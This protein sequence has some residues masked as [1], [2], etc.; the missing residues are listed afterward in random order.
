M[1]DSVALS[2]LI[3]RFALSF[4]MKDWG[5][6]RDCLADRVHTDYSDLRGAPAAT[7]DADDYVRA[8]RDALEHLLLHHV[9]GS[10][11]I[12]IRGASATCRA[13]MMIWRKSG[14]ETFA[15][16]ALYTFGARKDASW[17]L[18][19]ITQKVLWNDG[20]PTIHGGAVRGH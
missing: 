16:H 1:D 4:D 11:E 9:V 19:A 15:T 5:A 14:E 17:K 10:A 12:V 20:S 6:L 18:D 2:N 3:A 7:V 8:R 13:A